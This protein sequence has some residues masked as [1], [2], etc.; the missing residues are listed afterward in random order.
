VEHRG[1]ENQ[2][3]V[4]NKQD[5]EEAKA[6]MQETEKTIENSVDV[7]DDMNRD[8]S[9]EFLNHIGTK[10]YKFGAKKRKASVGSQY[11]KGSNGSRK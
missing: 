4:Q 1:V 8:K 11:S 9:F 6:D 10:Q 5:I 7:D 2:K 3:M